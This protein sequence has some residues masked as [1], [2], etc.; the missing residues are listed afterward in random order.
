MLACDAGGHRVH[1]RS[2]VRMDAH[3][4]RLVMSQFVSAYSP[5]QNT[6]ESSRTIQNHCAEVDFGCLHSEFWMVLDDS[7]VF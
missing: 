1:T 4:V 7:I 2:F 3:P 5:S 6:I